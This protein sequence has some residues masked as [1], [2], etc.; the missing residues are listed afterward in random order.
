MRFLN[1]KREGGD[2]GAER[3]ASRIAAQIIRWQISVAAKINRR[4]NRYTKAG[5]RK[6]LWVFCAVWI[7][8]ICFNFFHAQQTTTIR[9]VRPDYLPVH[10]GQPSDI[11]E[12]DK[13]PIP[14][15][16]SLT[17]KK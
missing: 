11:P 6:F 7:A 17:I 8:G 10:I 1:N 3:T 4:V 13:K 2:P 12:P 9:K 15:T 5:Q 16:D 14:R